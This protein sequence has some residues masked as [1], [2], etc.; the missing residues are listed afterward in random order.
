M[1]FRGPSSARQTDF[2]PLA[3]SYDGLR[4][5]DEQWSKT[6]DVLI[7]EG[8]LAG[9]RVLDVGCG[10]GRLAALLA[11]RY[12]CKVWGVDVSPEMLDVARERVPRSVGLKRAAAENLPFADGWFERAT[13][14]LVYHHLDRPRALPE[15]R[16]VLG[17]GGRLAFLTFDPAQFEGYYLNRYFPSF[18]EL[19]TARFPPAGVLARELR[20]AGFGDV[21]VTALHH[22][23]TI[24]RD[25]ALRKIRGRHISTFQLISADEYAEGLARAE[26]ELPPVVESPVE[27]LV[28][29][30]DIG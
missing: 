5:A 13:M 15:I 22:E 1:S 26:R 14:T 8:D 19:D 23:R 28:A 30:A 29:V 24:E 27:W 21:R 12:G 18:R 11:E 9:R 7:R 25:D 6:I 16:R 17:A 10:T 4:P 2:G 3:R 20:D